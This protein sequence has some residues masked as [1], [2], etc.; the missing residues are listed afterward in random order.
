MYRSIRAPACRPVCRKTERNTRIWRQPKRRPQAK[1]G[2]A[3][4][5]AMTWPTESV[6][7]THVT[8]DGALPPRVRAGW[9]FGVLCGGSLAR[10]LPHRRRRKLC[11]Q[12]LPLVGRIFATCVVCVDVCCKLRSETSVSVVTT[13]ILAGELLERLPELWFRTPSNTS[14]W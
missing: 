10:E 6:Q 5:E 1:L 13:A 9:G 4:D 2:V 11:P 7:R 3:S 8:V 14:A 12:P